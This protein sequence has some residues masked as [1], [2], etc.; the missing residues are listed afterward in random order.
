MADVLYPLHV[1]TPVDHVERLHVGTPVDH[2]ERLY[3][4]T[5]VPNWAVID[6]GNTATGYGLTPYGTGGYGE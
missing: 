6:D 3:A 4:G 2:V 5:P 1:G